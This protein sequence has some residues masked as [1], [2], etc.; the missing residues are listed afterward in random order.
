MLKIRKE[1]GKVGE[2]RGSTGNIEELWKRK[3]ELI[4]KEEEDTYVFRV[5]KAQRSPQ[6]G[7]R[8]KD[9]KEKS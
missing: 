8:R 1:E 3:R 7:T 5:K 6:I 2:R 4:E 9:K